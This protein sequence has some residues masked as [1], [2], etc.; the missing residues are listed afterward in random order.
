MRRWHI[1]LSL[2][3]IL[4]VLPVLAKPAYTLEFRSGPCPFES[5]STHRITCGS[6]ELPQ[7]RAQ[8]DGK[9]VKLAVAVFSAS[10]SNPRPDPLIYLDGGPGN[11][12]LQTWGA[13]FD[14]NFSP[15]AVDR[16]VIL[17]DYRGTGYSEPDLTCTESQDYLLER[18]AINSD[19]AQDAGT[20]NNNEVI[21]HCR[22]RLLQ[23]DVDLGMY[24]SAIIAQDVVDIWTALGYTEVNLLGGSYGTRLALTLLR[25]HPK[26]IRSVILDGVVPPQVD[27]ITAWF[28]RMDRVLE[29][30]FDACEADLAC[31]QNYPDLRRVTYEVAERLQAS[32]VTLTIDVPNRGGGSDT[33]ANQMNA[34]NFF[35]TLFQAFYNDGQAAVLPRIIYNAYQGDFHAFRQ[36]YSAP[37]NDL[38]T[39]S[40]GLSLTISCNEEYPFV[41]LSIV[42]N[43]SGLYPK[44]TRFYQSNFE[45]YQLSTVP[46]FSDNPFC[47]DWHSAQP[48]PVENLPV[49]SY[50]PVLVLS[51]QF[52]PVT[53]PEWGELAAK[54]LPNS[55]V[56][57]FP[58]LGHGVNFSGETCALEIDLSFLKQPLR[59]PSADCLAA[60]EL[61]FDVPIKTVKLQT[62]T[63]ESLGITIAHPQDWVEFS[64]GFF[65]AN[66]HSEN[67]VAYQTN[68]SVKDIP[69]TIN[70]IREYYG[71]SDMPETQDIIV[72][73]QRW[74]IKRMIANKQ[75]HY[76]TVATTV[77]YGRTI[78]I[79]FTSAS[80]AENELLYNE[81]LLP[82]LESVH[83]L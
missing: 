64:P 8:P 15:F 12:T 26:G 50:T 82:A 75:Y 67:N 69:G 2:V 79:I 28:F 33:Y 37:Y 19:P 72:N 59:K 18:L 60:M 52:D 74:V 55:F 83:F 1:I 65:G 38:F 16:D 71:I 46:W 35:S 49:T 34:R 9:Q 24:S 51:G 78:V 81:F 14:N 43:L 25:D 3:I 62:R 58:G 7:N 36:L 56:Y 47:A 80:A 57:T 40:G 30:L 54:T 21:Q 61:K 20:V 44:L 11:Y 32:P 4:S 68:L 10:G 23:Q 22:D 76:V 31:K 77:Y 5:S 29:A 41:D 70:L 13:N 53:P 6:I 66:P 73:K 42:R 63:V 48:N 45:D 27:Q 17:M 39:F